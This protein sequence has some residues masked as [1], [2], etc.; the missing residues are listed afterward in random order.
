MVLFGE[1][2][3]SLLLK[4]GKG[5]VEEQFLL[6]RLAAAAFDTYTMA[7]VLSRATR[8]LN[9]NLPSASHEQ[10]LAQVWCYE[11]S[12]LHCIILSG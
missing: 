1:A 12:L 10:L 11:V 8:S 2:V 3:E 7:V 5:V 4:Y 9:Q 6:N